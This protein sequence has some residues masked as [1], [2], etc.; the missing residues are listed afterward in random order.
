[1]SADPKGALFYARPAFAAFREL[2][3]FAVKDG[4]EWRRASGIPQYGLWQS[5][6]DA[7]EWLKRHQGQYTVRQVAHTV[8]SSSP[9][10]TP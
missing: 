10:V 9:K 2:W 5:Q 6:L 1:M 4:F 3:L 8:F 7:T